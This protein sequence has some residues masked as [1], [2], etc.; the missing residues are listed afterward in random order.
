MWALIFYSHLAVRPSCHTCRF[1]NLNREG[2]LTIGDFWGVEKQ[3][4]EYLVP[5]GASL[6]L[7]NSDKGKEAFKEISDNL[8][9]SLSDAVQAL[10]DTLLYVTKPHS[11]RSEFWNDYEKMSFKSVTNRYL[12]LGKKNE[13]KRK[14]KRVLRLPFR[15]IKNIMK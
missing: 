14:L 6:V 5:N 13:Y 8:V 4:P 3:H 10:P 15:L 12:D 1:A 9:C 2:D 7:I 11:N